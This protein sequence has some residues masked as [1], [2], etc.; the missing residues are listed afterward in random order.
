MPGFKAKMHQ[1]W[2]PLGP[3]TLLGSLQH[4]A[5]PLPVFNGPTSKGRGY[6]KGKVWEKWG[7]KWIRWEGGKRE[8]PHLFKLTLSSVPPS[9]SWLHH[10]V[11]S[12]PLWGAHNTPQIPGWLEQY[13]IALQTDGRHLCF[14]LSPFQPM[15]FVNNENSIRCKDQQCGFRLIILCT[16]DV[17][18]YMIRVTWTS[19][20]PNLSHVYQKVLI[21]QYMRTIHLLI[22]L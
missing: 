10:W 20:L 5:R 18:C 21:I 11:C 2:F 9:K 17:A 7:R 22:P 13:V 1:I 6:G 14:I 19:K 8:V 4:S 16:T 3:K 12:G 15:N